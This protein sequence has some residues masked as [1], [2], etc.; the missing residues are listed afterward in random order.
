MSTE[1]FW[2]NSSPSQANKMTHNDQHMLFSVTAR[3]IL[4]EQL[5]P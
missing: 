5:V 3:H 1:F 4:G 2:T